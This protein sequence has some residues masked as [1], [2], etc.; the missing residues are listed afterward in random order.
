[1]RQRAF[2]YQNRDY[3]IVTSDGEDYFSLAGFSPERVFE[4]EGKI[5]EYRCA[6]HCH[7]AVYNN[8]EDKE[9]TGISE[10]YTGISRQIV[11]CFRAWCRLA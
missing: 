8:P 7:E 3:F 1:M 11:C 2:P 10:F 9:N 4:I 6:I 5:T